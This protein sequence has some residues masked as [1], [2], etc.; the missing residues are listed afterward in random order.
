MF[1]CCECG[2]VFEEP[3]YWE[4]THNL[5]APPYEQWSGC[6]HC[7]GSYAETYEC[8]CCGDWITGDYVKTDNGE[9][10]CENCIVHYELGEE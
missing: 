7:G 2:N 6:P 3:V 5:D 10:Y 9:R 8:D 1:V 4:E